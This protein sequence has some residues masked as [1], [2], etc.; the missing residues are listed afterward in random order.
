MAEVYTPI[1]QQNQP[2]IGRNLAVTVG[3]TMWERGSTV[4]R[5]L[6]NGSYNTNSF[7][8]TWLGWKQTADEMERFSN[9]NYKGGMNW[10]NML[11]TNARMIG[12]AWAPSSWMM[13]ADLAEDSTRVTGNLVNLAE[14]KAWGAVYNAAGTVDD[15]IYSADGAIRAT[16]AANFKLASNPIDPAKRTFTKTGA[17]AASNSVINSFLKGGAGTATKKNLVLDYMWS[18]WFT[19]SEK[20][21]Q[22]GATTAGRV[23]AAGASGSGQAATVIE[24]NM[25][26]YGN[27]SIGFINKIYSRTNLGLGMR[28]AGGAGVEGISKF[29]ATTRS[30]FAVG[31]AALKAYNWATMAYYGTKAAYKGWELY[32]IKA[33]LA[34]YK[35]VGSQLTRPA[36]SSGDAGLLTGIPASNRMRAVQAIQG[37]RLNARSALGSEASL[38]SGHFG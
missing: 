6:R 32:S 33:P 38:L 37:S 8:T 16:Q 12:S 27:S 22:T 4:Y 1:D 17:R 19:P 24:T 28:A 31:G 11:P 21:V 20:A 5:T 14:G 2:S 23:F 29:A 7:A 13:A 18:I 26:G 36:F 25:F 15:L 9:P 3:S 35:M 34:A 30:I 10:R